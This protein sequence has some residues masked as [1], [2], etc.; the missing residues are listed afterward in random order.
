MAVFAQKDT[1]ILATSLDPRFKLKWTH[2][3][4]LEKYTADLVTKACQSSRAATSGC[5]AAEA[6]DTTASPPKK[7]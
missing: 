4:E 7:T 2:G 1:Y 5:S 3:D 6:D